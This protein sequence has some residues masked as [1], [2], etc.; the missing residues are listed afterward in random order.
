MDEIENFARYIALEYLDLGVPFSQV[1]ESHHA[2][3]WPEPDLEMV[4]DRANEILRKVHKL[5]EKGLP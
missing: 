1:Y 4:H 3:D 2:D 5:L